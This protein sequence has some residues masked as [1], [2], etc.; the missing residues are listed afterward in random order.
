MTEIS[1]RINR[2]RATMLQQN[3]AACII[4]TNDPHASEYVADHWKART[5]F[6][7]FTGSAG[8]L[9]VTTSKAG[10]WTDS[11]YF[12]QAAD[13][14]QGSTIELFKM[15]EANVPTIA[16]WLGS[17]LEKGNLI[18]MNA[19]LFSI[20]TI[21]QYHEY[22]SA[23]EI[24]L[25]T[26]TDLISAA[27][28]NRPALPRAPLFIHEERFAGK[29][30]EEKIDWVRKLMTK[31]NANL[32]LLN[33]LDEIAWLFNI[34]GTDV[35]FNP[36]T[37]AYAAIEANQ[38][39]LFVDLQK[40]TAATKTY[41]DTHHIIVKEYQSVAEYLSS[42]QGKTILLDK[43]KMNYAI[44]EQLTG[45]NQV[46]FETS[47]VLQLKSLKNDTEIKGTRLAMLKDGVALTRF[48]MWL[49]S[50][51]AQGLCVSELSAANKLR[52]F[53][54]E[55]DLFFGES[56]APIVGYK[57]HGAIVHYSASES[58]NAE[59]KPDGLLLI[60]SGAQFPHGTT[61]ITRT[62]ALGCPTEKEKSD[63]TLVLKGHI[64]L[65]QAVFPAG[66]CGYQ[67][68]ALAR[69]FLWK[70]G[71]NYGHGTGHGVGCF[72]CVH[73]GPQAIRPDANKTPLETG[74]IISNEPGIYRTG[75]HG[76]RLENLVLVQSCNFSDKND[77]F[78]FET[79]TLF[80][81]DTKAISISLMTAEETVWLNTYHET[82][83]NKLSPLLN[84]EEKTWLQ[85]KCQAIHH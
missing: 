80:P 72:L 20:A 51:F 5:Y 70:N 81:F 28:H 54:A 45:K 24:C 19:D 2:L 47:P 41:F 73:E 52:G 30:C 85:K 62:F 58:I 14:L 61:D 3:I 15:G 60:D 56:F 22:F 44:Y 69:Q 82:V 49:E 11:R 67:L 37:I 26:K 29:S 79:L 4:P 33:A 46:K 65:A 57:A 39:I 25:D 64:A 40:L 7:G 66:T 38:A 36:V 35:D 9:I 1:N 71:L 31:V 21:Q 55:Q 50:S 77:F 59:I 10:L 75:E 34:R 8:T 68:D 48:S 18:A 42:L 17:E 53:R 84:Q 63:F 23:L 12:L 16:T 43:S 83:F 6:S 27:W 74:M 78:C 32:L 76:I 13:E